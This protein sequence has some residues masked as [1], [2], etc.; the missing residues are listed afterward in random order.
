MVNQGR[1]RGV[2][3]RTSRLGGRRVTTAAWVAE[4]IERLSDPTL[5][6]DAPAPTQRRRS[7]EQAA[8]RLAAAGF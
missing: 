6:P 7:I 1:V 8:A 3:L 4:F 5:P 2:R